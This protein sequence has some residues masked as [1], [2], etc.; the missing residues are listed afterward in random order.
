MKIATTF[1]IKVAVVGP[2]SAGK[3][4]LINA[5]LVGKY[6]EVSIRRTTAG[7]N[8]FRLKPPEKSED[9]IPNSET[10]RSMIPDKVVELED[11]VL[12]EI[13]KDNK[14]LRELEN[15]GEKT[16]DI[17]GIQLCECRKDTKLVIVDIP[18][19]NEADSSS[20]YRDYVANKWDQFD[21][22]IL[23]M[24]ARHG[25]NTEEQIVLLELIKSNLTVKKDLP[26]IV[27]FN[28]IDELDIH[29]EKR[30]DRRGSCQDNIHVQY[31]WLDGYRPRYH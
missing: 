21:C 16:F 19:I 9:G 1:E 25:V 18:G 8:F 22:V 5:L 29:E 30:I 15:V 14:K 3:S 4:T 7:V 2:V 28:K 17:E 23:V 13:T 11:I 12:Q 10:K 26:V 6:S 24:D 31:S 27:L 20:K